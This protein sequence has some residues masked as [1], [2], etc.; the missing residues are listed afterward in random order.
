MR[1]TRAGIDGAAPVYCR[2]TVNGER[3][4]FSINRK[5]EVLRWNS[6]SGFAKGTKEDALTLNSFIDAVRN[7]IYGIHKKLT[8]KKEL[9]TAEIIKNHYQGK[10]EKQYSLIDV[11]RH[12]NAEIK[13]RINIDIAKGTFQKFESILKHVIEFMKKNYGRNDMFLS[14]LNHKF[15]SDFEHFLKT[16]K[17]INN[18]TTVKY[19]RSLRKIINIAIENDWLAKDPFLKYKGTLKEVKRNF[20]T[21]DELQ[22]IVNLNLKNYRL[23]TVRDI[24]VFACYTGLA[25]IDIF[26]LTEDNILLGIDGERWIFKDRAK[27]D[28]SSKIPLLP[29]AIEIIERYNQN[30]ECTASGKLFPVKSNQ[31]TNAYLREIAD[32][33]GIEKYLTFHLARHTFATTVTLLNGVP[34]ETVSSM[35]GHKSIRTTQIYSKVVE[36]KISVDM[37]MLKEKLELRKS[38]YLIH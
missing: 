35:L 38:N 21:T 10:T 11:F 7:K 19:I 4:E 20:L 9:I 26:N 12:H 17:Q 14:Q 37:K 8:D 2:V 31:K 27:T 23:Q 32:L 6:Q 18:N 5:F 36:E 1:K 34:I 3:A 33:A 13:E 25:Y 15:I 30:E 29:T 28:V 24:F 16:K 22:T